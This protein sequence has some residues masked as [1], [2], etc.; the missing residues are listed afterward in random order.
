MYT[1]QWARNQGLRVNQKI[2]KCNDKLVT[3]H[4]ELLEETSRHDVLDLRLKNMTSSLTSVNEA[5]DRDIRILIDY[6][7]DFFVTMI[8]ICTGETA[9]IVVRTLMCLTLSLSLS[10]SLYT[11]IHTHTN[12]QTTVGTQCDRNQ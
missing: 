1:N 11:H 3:T 6:V 9:V 2:L 10:L 7:Y 5:Q 8:I 12:K 4:G